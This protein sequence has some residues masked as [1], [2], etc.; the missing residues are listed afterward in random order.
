METLYFI[1]FL[2]FDTLSTKA[3]EMHVISNILP[4]CKLTE[5]L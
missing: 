4:K 5:I 2:V 3:F 1:I